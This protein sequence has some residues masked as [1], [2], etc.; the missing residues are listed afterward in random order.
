MYYFCLPSDI[1]ECASNP[2]QNGAACVDQIDG[3]N[4]TCLAGYIGTNC[5]T[6]V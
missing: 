5:Q 6:G 3:Y 1:D 4:C 2:C